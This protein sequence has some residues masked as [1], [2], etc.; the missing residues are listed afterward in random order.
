MSTPRTTF[1]VLVCLV[2]TYGTSLAQAPSITDPTPSNP[3]RCVGGMVT[4]SVVASSG[5]P[6]YSYQ[7][8]FQSGGMGAWSNV[9]TNSASLA[10]ASL[11]KADE[12]NYRCT[13]T[14]SATPTPLSATSN[15]TT[16]TVDTTLPTFTGCPGNITGSALASTCAA[17]ATWTAP[18][19]SDD[20]AVSMTTST[21]NPGDSF[22]VGVT[23]V[24]YTATDSAGNQGFCSFTVTITDDEDP[25]ISGC[26]ANINLTVAAGT[27]AQV[28]TWTAPTAT[29]NCPGS[30]IVQTAGLTSGSSF[31]VGTS[32]VTYT[33]TDAAGRTA[34]CSFDV[35][36]VDD[37]DPV[38]SG[39]PANINLTVAAGTCAQVATWTAPTATDNCP[40]SSIVQTAGSTSGSSFPVGTSTVT[41]TATD[42][43]G[44]TATCSFDVIVVDDEDPV[45]SGCPANINLTVVAGTCAQVATWTA[46][47][48]ADNCPGSS[49]VQTAGLTSGSSFPVGMSTVTYTATDAAG[50]TATCSFDV[51][52][53]DDEDP[54]ISGC[55]ANINLT[56]VAGTC[57]QVATWTAPTVADN[58]PGSSI[59]QTAGLTSGSSFPVGMSTVTYTATDAG[60]RTA[61]CSFDVIVVDDE[62]PVISGYP[63]NINLTVAAGTCAQ[64]GTWTTPTVADN[65]PGSSIVQTAGLTSGSSFPVGTS[66]VTYTATDAAGR[67]ATCSFDVIVV[68]DEDPVISGCPANINLTVAAG[69]CAQVGT[70]TAPTVADN[71]PGSSIVQTAG[72]T[73]GSSFPVGMSTVTYTATDAA[74]RTATCS[75]DVIGGGR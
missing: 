62:D 20:C 9:G 39:C 3:T 31:P 23:T 72:L 66:T 32:T 44:R 11:V 61:T 37:E 71:C 1:A 48:V 17:T 45:I 13:V 15:A 21:H 10:F 64:V 68:D 43:A 5:T 59:V 14:D 34:T 65:C 29:D 22:S 55:P 33:A 70:W 19:A 30:S 46:P 24:T 49:I 12:G 2:A 69:T 38:I 53:V 25:V 27:C 40:G 63:A 52:V 28:A 57:A 60:G 16:L 36:V 35:I 47:T 4:F 7:W 26:P 50:R 42:A 67:T 56:V 54:V 41:Y 58:C 73:S 6:G 18:T 75:F 8:E 74:G 51:I